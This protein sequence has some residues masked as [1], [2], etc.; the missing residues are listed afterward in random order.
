MEVGGGRAALRLRA[1]RVGYRLSI[2]HASIATTATMAMIANAESMAAIAV[3]NGQHHPA[4]QTLTVYGVNGLD[5]LGR[6]IPTPR[7]SRRVVPVNRH[8]SR[9]NTLDL[10][11][12]SPIP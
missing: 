3:G 9:S 10:C 6:V 1:A 7:E 8:R 2:H 5:P 4:R 12:T 11:S